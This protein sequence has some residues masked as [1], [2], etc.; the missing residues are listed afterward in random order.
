MFG[1]VQTIFWLFNLLLLAR[2]LLSWV[3]LDP[4]HP[5]VQFIY[6]TTEPILAPIRRVIPPVGM[7]DLSPLVALIGAS[8]LESLIIQ[9]MFR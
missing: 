6:N 1:V 8:I 9:L 5:I 4:S 7:M 3:Q 2:V